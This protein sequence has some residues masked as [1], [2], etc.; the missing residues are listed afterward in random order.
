M[1]NI[2]YYNKDLIIK[3]KNEEKQGDDAVRHVESRRFVSVLSS[4]SNTKTETKMEINQTASPTVTRHLT[5]AIF[6]LA[7]DYKQ[8]KVMRTHPP[9]GLHVWFSRYQS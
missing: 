1:D 3:K 9:R 8:V 2:T 5:A 4:I 7:S 6:N